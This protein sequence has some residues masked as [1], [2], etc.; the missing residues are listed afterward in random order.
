M[1][2][3][4]ITPP[5][6]FLLDERVFM[7]LGILK[8]AASLE[9]VGEKV[10]H[11]DLSGVENFMDVVAEYAQSAKKGTVYGLTA[12]TPQ[13]TSATRIASYLRPCGKVTLGGPHATLVNAAAKRETDPGRATKAM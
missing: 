7:S 9:A 2:V 3:C 5:S 8:V 6:E 11:L 4:L 10:E 12:T 13:M 1:S